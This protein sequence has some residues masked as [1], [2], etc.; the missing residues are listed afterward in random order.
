[1]KLLQRFFVILFATV[2]LVS[3]CAN[4]DSRS[5]TSPSYARNYAVIEAIE[6]TNTGSDGIAGSGIGLGTVIGG[7]VGGV[8]GHQ[9]GSGR[10]NTAA[11]VVGAVGGAV[12]GHEIEK[13][14]QS[15]AAY[16]VRV[17]LENGDRQTV[18]QDSISDLRVG[19][20]VRIEHDQVSRY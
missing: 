7:V 17:R 6:R 2:A 12:V 20:R 19:D 15:Q 13:N 16:Q 18:T 10:G 11:T 3:G 9:V 14:R 1:M 5:T 4:T 8:V